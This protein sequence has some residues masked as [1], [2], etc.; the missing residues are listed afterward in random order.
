MSRLLA[1]LVLV[2]RL[3]RQMVLSA[4]ATSVTI[5]FASDAPRRGFAR[6]EYA[7]LSEAGAMLLAAM[8]TL[9]PGTSVVDI[10]T[11]RGELLLHVLD[12]EDIESTLSAIRREFIN[13]IRTLL[14]GQ[15]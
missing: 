11:E 4:W 3:V 7:D 10:D 2:W 15:S 9:T 5:L 12:T 8:V 13:P 6:L 14:G 1:L